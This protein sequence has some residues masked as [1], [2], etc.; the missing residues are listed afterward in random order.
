M[1]V[2]AVRAQGWPVPA[3]YYTRG[4]LPEDIIH[5]RYYVASYFFG[6]GLSFLLSVSQHWEST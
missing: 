1:L 4:F 5:T 6:Y 2:Y 3:D